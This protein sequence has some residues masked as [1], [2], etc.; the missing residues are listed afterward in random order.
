VRPTPLRRGVWIFPSRPAG[1]LVEA[2]VAAEEAGL[3][4]VWLADEGVAREPITVLAA[5]AQRTSRIQLA[6]GI[7]SPV[8]RHPGAIAASLATLDELSAGRAMLGLGVGGQLSLAPFGLHADRPVALVRDA[9]ETA[10]AVFRR[11][12]SGRYEPPSHAMPARDVPIWVGARG[13]QLVR[14]AARLADGLFL[15]GCTPEQLHEIIDNA[16]TAGGTRMAIY[17]SVAAEPS[18]TSEHRWDDVGELLADVVRQ[19][20]PASIGVNLVEVYH[21]ATVELVGQ[22]RRAADLLRSIRRH[23][24]RS[25]S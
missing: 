6:T 2:I 19:H 13:P 24:S 12:A 22:V 8:L 21:D 20:H 5:A 23:D 10:R 4:E 7:T 9:V 14:L 16:L 17:Q 3:D 25:T 18:S 15:S 1:E 11:E